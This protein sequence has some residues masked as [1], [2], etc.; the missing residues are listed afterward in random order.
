MTHLLLLALLLVVAAP[1]GAQ[2]PGAP[3]PSS[4]QGYLALV[5]PATGRQWVPLNTS[6]DP[7]AIVGYPADWTIVFRSTGTAGEHR[8]TLNGASARIITGSVGLP[9]NAVRYEL[10]FVHDRAVTGAPAALES[11]PRAVRY[12]PDL[13]RFDRLVPG[14]WSGVSLTPRATPFAG[15]P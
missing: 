7:P 11:F 14:A 8:I 1:A 5:D 15:L 12:N 13:W 10:R 6:F 2:P 9:T 4:I 3:E